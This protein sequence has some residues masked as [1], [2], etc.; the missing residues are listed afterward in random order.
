MIASGLVFSLA[1]V[2]FSLSPSLVPGI[3]L[4]LITG[5]ASTVFGTIIGT[6]IQLATSNE[7]RGRVMS[8]YTI[9]LI[10]LPSLGALG[11]G[12]AAEWLGGVQGAPKA[13]LIGAAI[14]AFVLLIVAPFYW[15]RAVSP[16]PKPTPAPLSRA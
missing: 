7:L 1:L 4:L 13:V 16:T 3:V 11:S 15:K 14:V 12:T 6:F 2:A 8:L 9:T 10:G 5:V